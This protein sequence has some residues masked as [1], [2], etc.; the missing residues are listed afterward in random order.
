MFFPPI[1]FKSVSNFFQRII[2]KQYTI[3]KRASKPKTQDQNPGAP[4]ESGRE[5]APRASSNF[6]YNMGRHVKN[7]RNPGEAG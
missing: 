4:P 6:D 1:I 5:P 2:N 3:I 7:I